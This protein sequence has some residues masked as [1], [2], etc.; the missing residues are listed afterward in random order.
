[1]RK[2]IAGWLAG[3]WLCLLLVRL[4]VQA[5]NLAEPIQA[6]AYVLMEQESGTVLAEEQADVPLPMGMMAK[7]MTVLLAAEQL[8]SGAWTLETVLT[9]SDVVNTCEGATVW[10]TAGETMTVADLLKAVIIGNANDAAAVL[11]EGVSGSVPAF[12][13][14]M[15]ARAFD[16]GMR[17]TILT[18]PQGYDDEKQC[19]TARDFAKLCRR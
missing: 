4:P 10:L 5:A 9:A 6:Q 16:L 1:M 15:N 19:T 13:M 8:E 3:I 14:E 12:V 18:N 11:A 7:L 17:Q 2:I